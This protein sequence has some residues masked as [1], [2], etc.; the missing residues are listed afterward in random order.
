MRNS[1]IILGTKYSL[2]DYEI[3][4]NGDGFTVIPKEGNSTHVRVEIETTHEESW[5]AGYNFRRDYR[6][7]KCSEGY[8]SFKKNLLDSW[9]GSS[10]EDFIKESFRPIGG[11]ISFS[12]EGD[13]PGENHY[14]EM[15]ISDYTPK[16]GEEITNRNPIPAIKK[17]LHEYIVLDNRY[18]WEEDEDCKEED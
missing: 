5:G 7:F 8:E 13:D 3:I 2:K 4:L 17:A 11:F 10:Y 16:K 14:V 1:S 15:R 12:K 6:I 18:Y 9:K